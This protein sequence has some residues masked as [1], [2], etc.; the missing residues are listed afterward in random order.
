MQKK[1]TVLR[2][3]AATAIATGALASVAE[4]NRLIGFTAQAFTLAAGALIYI[5]YKEDVL[6]RRMRMSTEFNGL[7][8]S[9]TLLALPIYLLRSRGLIRG[10]IATALFY[11][12]MVGWAVLA[13]ISAFVVGFI[14]VA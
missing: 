11:L 12:S 7:V 14:V 2:A 3:I 1:K 13:G 4:A 6:Q 5:W 10:L 8:I 9:F